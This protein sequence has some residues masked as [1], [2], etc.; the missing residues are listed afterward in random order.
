MGLVI[1]VV[2]AMLVLILF[3]FAMGQ[4][5][6]RRERRDIGRRQDE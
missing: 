6:A 4:W 5:L 3:G 2:V 1:V